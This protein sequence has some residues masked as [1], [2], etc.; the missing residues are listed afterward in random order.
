[1]M[2]NVTFSLPERTIGRLRKR[3]AATGKKKGVISELVDAAI[4]SYLDNLESPTGSQTFTALK[5]ERPVAEAASLQEL[6]S[7]LRSKGVDPRTVRIVS[8]ELLESTGHM[9]LRVHAD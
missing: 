8:S 4:T 2:T 1:M 9:G 3:A 5:G 7:A 6:A